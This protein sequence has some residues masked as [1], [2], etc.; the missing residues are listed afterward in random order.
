MH[1]SR[2]TLRN[3]R[4]FQRDSFVFAPKV[5]T[6][7]G[8]N[9]S[10]KSNAL[11]GL[12]LLLDESLPRRSGVLSERDFTRRLTDFRGHWIVLTVWLDELTDEEGCQVVRHLSGT[13]NSPTDSGSVRYIFRPKYHVRKALHENRTKP[14]DKRR[15]YL[16]R[17]QIDDYEHLFT[18]R[19]EADFG[20][21]K[22]YAEIVGNVDL[23]LFPDPD[24]DDTKAIG[25]RFAG[26]HREVSCTYVKALRDVVSDLRSYQRSPLLALLRDLEAAI[27]P[28]S[29]SELIDKVSSLNSQIGSLEPVQS[30][31]RGLAETLERSLGLAYAPNIAIESSLHPEIERLLQ[32]LV[33]KTGERIDVDFLGELSSMGLG[34]AN[35]IFISLK[36]LEY[37]IKS[38]LDK[39]LHLL[40]LEEPEAHIH[41]H[42]QK[43]LFQRHSLDNTQV[44]VTS[45]STH[46]SSASRI[47]SMNVVARKTHRSEVY[48]P[49]TGLSDQ[50]CERIERYLDA[51]RS[52]LLYSKGVLLVEGDAEQLLLPTLTLSALGVSLDELGVGVINV[53]GTM[54]AHIAQLFHRDRLRRRCAIVTDLDQPFEPIPSDPSN[55]TKRS[56]S[57]RRAAVLGDRRRTRLQKM[58]TINPFISPYFARHTF[59]IDLFLAGN[60]EIYQKSVDQ[61]WKSSQSR[62]KAKRAF[63]FGS[64]QACCETIERAG[65]HVGKGWL[66]LLLAGH[67]GSDVAFPVYL[68]SAL[69]HACVASLDERSLREMARFRLRNGSPAVQALAGTLLIEECSIADLVDEIRVADLTDPFVSLVDESGIAL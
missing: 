65:R 2:Y 35:L 56:A 67:V 25:V 1:I 33:L 48:C 4:N 61:I 66:A 47:R 15:D 9:G 17:L 43:T 52:T 27:D 30:I 12:R 20:D 10:G 45:H 54:F 46:I 62:S 40:L 37:E 63:A 68:A 50:S 24:N 3:F 23:A 13:M 59:E 49:S 32:R 55:D 64:R 14:L 8:E 57:L 53:G 29:Q 69:G 22:I 11:Y 26:I 21:D 34:G 6:V 58:A 39:S 60:V 7:L 16:R 38:S 5:N 18:G 36:L 41:T 42:L 51:V 44:I 31:A 28:T 19:G